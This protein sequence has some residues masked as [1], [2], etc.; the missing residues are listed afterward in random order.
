MLRSRADI[1]FWKALWERLPDFDYAIDVAVRG[2]LSSATVITD[3]M[4]QHLSAETGYSVGECRKSFV[5]LI[6]T[7]VLKRRFF[8]PPEPSTYRL[9]HRSVRRTPIGGRRFRPPRGNGKSW[10]R[11][12]GVKGS[13]P[14]EF[15]WLLGTPPD[16]RT[17]LLGFRPS[18]GKLVEMI[19]P[20]DGPDLENFLAKL[21]PRVA[22]FCAAMADGA[23]ID[24]A[25]EEAGL[26]PAQISLVLPKLRAALTA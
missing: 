16:K 7:T 21:H 9:T 15:A 6:E 8:N 23:N 22:A 2:A 14:G 1:G 26:T 17:T 18:S 4:E 19:G 12:V 24:V 5:R 13:K 11:P 20:S 10:G 3:G 25:G